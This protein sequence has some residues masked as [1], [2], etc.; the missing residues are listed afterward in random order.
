MTC[1]GLAAAV[2]VFGVINLA[3]AMPYLDAP[4]N[5]RKEQF[6]AI[7][8][9]AKVMYMASL[10][11][12]LVG[13]LSDIAVFGFFKRLTGQRF[14]WLRATGF[15]VISQ[16]IDSFIVSRRAFLARQADL[17]RSGQ[18]AGA[19][20]GDSRDR[21]HRLHAEVR[22]RD[23]DHAADLRGALRDAPLVR[24]HPDR[25]APTS[26]VFRDGPPDIQN[27]RSSVE[28]VPRPPSAAGRRSRAMA[29]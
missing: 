2:F 25:G 13:Q 16:F 26:A 3:Q 12:Y 17:R 9:S 23:R 8:G 22:D 1:L 11:A 15:T 5:V 20:V 29:R 24:P 14:V 18:P 6:D 21:H 4:Y 19:A 7:F 27:P 28:A 10:C